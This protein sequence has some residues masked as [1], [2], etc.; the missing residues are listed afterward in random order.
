MFGLSYVT[1]GCC[2]TCLL[3]TGKGWP[4]HED[5]GIL[6]MG[7]LVCIS[8]ATMWHRDGLPEWMA[9]IVSNTSGKGRVP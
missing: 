3:I 5:F 9:E 8:D 7:S 2:P 4:I 6:E 1:H